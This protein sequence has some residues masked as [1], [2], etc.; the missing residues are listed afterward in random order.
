MPRQK[1]LPGILPKHLRRALD[2]R[3]LRAANIGK[4]S[5]RR[6]HRSDPLNQIDNRQHRSRQYN[7]L[8]PMYRISG[9]HNPDVD[10]PAHTRAFQRSLAIAADNPPRK[11]LLPQRKPQRPANQPRPNNR[12]LPNRHKEMKT[13][14]DT[15]DTEDVKRNLETQSMPRDSWSHVG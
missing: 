5:L 15:E 2:N 12:D 14:E 4:Q 13:T 11:L 9:I 8:A 6:Q 3:S 10:R 7:D 1:P